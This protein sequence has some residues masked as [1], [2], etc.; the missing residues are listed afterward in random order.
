MLEGIHSDVLQ[1]NRL[2]GS[3]RITVLQDL[4]RA[5]IQAG[6]LES[7]IAALESAK[8]EEEAEEEVKKRCAD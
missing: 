3:D 7:S 1:W 4:T 6:D 5:N 8:L 2:S